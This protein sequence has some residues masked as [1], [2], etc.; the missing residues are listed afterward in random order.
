MS[1]TRPRRRWGGRCSCQRRAPP[2]DLVGRGRSRARVDSRRAEDQRE[3]RVG[4]GSHRWCKWKH[5]WRFRPRSAGKKLGSA[6]R[7]PGRSRAANTPQ[8]TVCADASWSSRPR[9]RPLKLGGFAD[10]GLQTP[11]R[12]SSGPASVGTLARR[13]SAV[14]NRY[15][16]MLIDELAVRAGCRNPRANR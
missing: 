10:G 1:Q 13:G 11:P 14:W 3:G 16:F 7:A 8:S 6:R 2:L 12:L 15:T 5:A 4:T 9:P